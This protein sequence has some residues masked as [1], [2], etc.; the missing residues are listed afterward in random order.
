[1]EDSIIYINNTQKTKRNIDSLY[2]GRKAI[3]EEHYQINH[4]DISILVLAY[5]RLEKTKRC[6]NSI[7]ENTSEIN[8]QLILVDNGSTDGTFDYFKSVEYENKK[9]I[10]INQNLEVMFAFTINSVIELGRYYVMV[11]NDVILTPNWLNNML[12]CA[13]SDERIGM[14]CAMSSNVSNLQEKNLEFCDYND[15]MVKARNYNQTDSSKWHERLRLV[16]ILTL[17]KKE[18]I[19]AMGYPIIDCGFYHDFS[20]DDISFRVRRAGYKIILAKDTWVYHD[21]YYKKLEDKNEEDFQKSIDIGRQNFRDKYQGLDAWDD[22]NN[23]LMDTVAGINPPK[24]EKKIR[25]LGIDT[26]CGTPILDVKNKLRE[27]GCYDVGLSAFTQEAKYEIDLKTICEDIVVCD[28]EEFL[29]DNFPELFYDYIVLGRSINQYHEPQKILNDLLA[30]AKKGAQI[31][32]PLYN[33]FSF[34]EYLNILGSRDIY[35]ST[36]AYNISMEKMAAALEEKCQINDIKISQYKLDEKNMA[37]IRKSFGSGKE[38]EN[39]L[40]LVTENYWFIATK[41]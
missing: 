27:Y 12:R 35:N 41:N 37:F 26:K 13:E 40:R 18:A 14:V 3:S 6:V 24:G 20:D 38:K 23:Y 19:L 4:I 25:I 5:N 32:M 34:Y 15:M 22:V 28:R 31:I 21:H 36:F 11:P 33:T 8:Y 10:K 30:L 16:T 7:I 9:I 2:E 29:R 17:Y 39:L 1:M